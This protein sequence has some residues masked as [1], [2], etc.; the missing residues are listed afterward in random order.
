MGE[1]LKLA[2]G[3][4]G[5]SINEIV[6]KI[7]INEIYIQALEEDNFNVFSNRQAGEEA[8]IA[9]VNFLGL[10][11][12]ALIAEFNKGW[13]DSITAKEYI[14][15]AFSSDKKKGIKVPVIITS[16]VIIALFTVIAFSFINIPVQ[17]TNDKDFKVAESGKDTHGINNT[18]LTKEPAG[19]SSEVSTEEAGDVTDE[20]ADGKMQGAI[21]HG[22][23][24]EIIPSR[25]D[26]WIEVRVDD[27]LVL[28]RMVYMGEESMV[29]KGN[30]RI[31][32]LLGNAAAVDIIKNGESLGALGNE[33]QVVRRIIT[34]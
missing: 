16:L 32:I 4:K 5:L 27:E 28:Y 33:K 25:G 9:Y 21:V 29:F 23:M 24:V 6:S 15:A 19:E 22:L 13:A 7:K 2:R 26:C 3:K 18:T 10:N 11:R 34:P 31:D 14:K 12:D 20:K 8:L 17:Y 1:V 30:N